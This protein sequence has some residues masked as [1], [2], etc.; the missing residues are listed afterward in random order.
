VFGNAGFLRSALH[1]PK[2]PAARATLG[3][4]AKVVNLGHTRASEDRRT[5]EVGGS[6]VRGAPLLNPRVRQSRGSLAWP[7]SKSRIV[8]RAQPRRTDQCRVPRRDRD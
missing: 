8:S 6:G 5:V 4:R 3:R 7:S 2:E 1:T